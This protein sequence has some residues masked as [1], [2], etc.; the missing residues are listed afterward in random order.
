MVENF[1][2]SYAVWLNIA[3]NA[4]AT[5]CL[6]ILFVRM[7]GRKK[8]L[9]GWQTTRTLSLAGPICVL[10]GALMQMV[11]SFLAQRGLLQPPLPW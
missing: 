7:L 3:F 4:V 11:I 6:K 10:I 8:M 1:S 2:S 9:R 5:C